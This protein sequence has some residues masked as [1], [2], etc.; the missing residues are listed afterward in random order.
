LKAADYHCHGDRES[1]RIYDVCRAGGVYGCGIYM[2]GIYWK[3]LRPGSH[4]F[5]CEIAWDRVFA[6]NDGPPIEEAMNVRFGRD[7]SKW[8]NPCRGARFLPWA[9]GASKCVE[10]KTVE[11]WV[12]FLADRLPEQ[13]E[14]EIMKVHEAFHKADVR[15]GP[16]AVELGFLARLSDPGV[17]L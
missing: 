2:P 14:D 3:P 17:S 9:R 4:K 10:F 11:G 12:S 16:F 6:Q 15:F 7:R 5:R 13:L 8:P 1:W